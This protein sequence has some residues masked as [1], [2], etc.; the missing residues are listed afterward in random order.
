LSGPGASIAAVD[1]ALRGTGSGADDGDMLADA[2]TLLRHEEFA[3]ALPLFERA[4][5]GQP[6]RAEL[7]AY[8]SGAFLALGRPRDAQG[9]VDRAMTLDPT[10]F[11]SNQKAGELNL[12]LGDLDAAAEHFLAAVRVA[13][14]GSADEQA[15]AVA[16]ALVRRRQRSAISHHAS[17]PGVPRQTRSWLARLARPSR[18][19]GGRIRAPSGESATG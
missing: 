12:R 9:D 13:R 1:A 6:E 17:F 14:R 2:L 16:L 8:R 18:W 10:A 3:E 19:R 5:A 4:I 11:A 7:Y 15:A